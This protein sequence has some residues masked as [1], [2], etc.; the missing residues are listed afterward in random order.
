[1]I[2]SYLHFHF[3]FHCH[4]SYSADFSIHIISTPSF[5]EKATNML[6]SASWL[7]VFIVV[8]WTLIYRSGDGIA[9]IAA[10]VTAVSPLEIHIKRDWSL[11]RL[12]KKG[13]RVLMCFKVL[14]R[15]HQCKC[16]VNRI[17]ASYR[18]CSVGCLLFLENVMGGTQHNHIGKVI[19]QPKK[20]VAILRRGD[21]ANSMSRFRCRFRLHVQMMFTSQELDI[22]SLIY[23]LK[24][25]KGGK[26]RVSGYNPITAFSTPINIKK[27]NSLNYLNMTTFH[28]EENSIYIFFSINMTQ[29]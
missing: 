6:L 20:P 27:N 15:P 19:A 24:W 12:K 26:N 16:K 21:R 29:R 7:K 17:L 23:F 4:F 2:L 9:V 14:H 8:W 28:L 18:R 11:N 22:F 25:K 13:K 5:I 1:M 10:A 3:C